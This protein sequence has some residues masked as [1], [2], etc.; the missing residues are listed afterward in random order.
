MWSRQWALLRDLHQGCH[1][2]CGISFPTLPRS[3]Q[4]GG[5]LDSLDLISGNYRLTKS[6]ER[7]KDGLFFGNDLL[8]DLT[9]LESLT[10]YLLGKD[11]LPI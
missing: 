6:K 3:R 11:V 8:T 5:V 10:S 1:R 4:T 9:D 7:V 2:L